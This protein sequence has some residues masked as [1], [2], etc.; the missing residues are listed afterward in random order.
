MCSS[1]LGGARRKAWILGAKAFGK[2]L[3]SASRLA[4][5]YELLKQL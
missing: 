4:P 2:V 3:K 1:G 5:C